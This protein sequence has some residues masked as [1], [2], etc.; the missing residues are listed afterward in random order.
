[1]RTSGTLRYSAIASPSG[2]AEFPATSLNE[3]FI[4]FQGVSTWAQKQDA[5]LRW[6]QGS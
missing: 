5:P 3:A 6:A 4:R 2:R 1:M